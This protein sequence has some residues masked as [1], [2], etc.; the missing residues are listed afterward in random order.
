MRENRRALVLAWDGQIIPEGIDRADR[1]R[2]A[3]RGTRRD[4]GI[5]HAV[6]R[7]L[8][9]PSLE[10]RQY[11]RRAAVSLGQI[12]IVDAAGIEVMP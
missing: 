1:V 8:V 9:K 2:N 4:G 5:G 3:H 6:A 11:L 12:V 7:L 10:S